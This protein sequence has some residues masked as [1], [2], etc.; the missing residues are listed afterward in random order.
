MPSKLAALHASCP[1]EWGSTRSLALLLPLP[2][3]TQ[4]QVQHT[5]RRIRK[6]AQFISIARGG[7]YISGSVIDFEN[8]IFIALQ[9]PLPLPLSPPVPLRRSSDALR[10]QL[11]CC[12]LQFLRLI[13]HCN[14]F[15][16][17]GGWAAGFAFLSRDFPLEDFCFEFQ[18]NRGKG[19]GRGRGSGRWN[20]S[21][22]VLT[23]HSELN[24]SQVALSQVPFAVGCPKRGCL[25]LQKLQSK[26]G[27]ELEPGG[28]GGGEE[29][30]CLRQV[31][32]VVVVAWPLGFP[33]LSRS[34]P[35]LALSSLLK[36][37][38]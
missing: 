8:G 9:H 7:F 26:R 23:Q 15:S 24:K 34:L 33:A 29:A 11:A 14:T 12:S 20:R 1:H 28:G 30:E 17:S 31:V 27:W 35:P 36:H 32:A 13:W 19:S 22:G 18:Y 25:R 21:L 3:C 10:I 37:F 16:W 2:F 4:V 6:K 38:L 5:F